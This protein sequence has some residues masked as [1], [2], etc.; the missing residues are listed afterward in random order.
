MACCPSRPPSLSLVQ[1]VFV[2]LG[3]HCSHTELAGLPGLLMAARPPNRFFMCL[4]FRRSSWSGLELCT[5]Q[6]KAFQEGILL[7]CQGE[8]IQE[9][10]LIKKHCNISKRLPFIHMYYHF[11]FDI[12]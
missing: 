10:I 1:D 6:H 11:G 4:G 9:S 12:V 7:R 8:E 3:S 2:E 5:E